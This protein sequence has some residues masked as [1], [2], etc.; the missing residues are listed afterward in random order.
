MV[1]IVAVALAAT[2]VPPACCQQQMVVAPGPEVVSLT[3]YNQNFGLVRETRTL[4]LQEGLNWV[5]VEDVAAQIDPTSVHL[6]G[7]ELPSALSVREQNYEYDLISPEAILRKAVGE[8]VIVRNYLQNGE[9]QMREGT[10]LN[11][12]VGNLVVEGPDG[13]VLRPTGEVSLRELPEGL[14]SRPALTWKLLSDRA[15]RQRAELSY[16]TQGISWVANYVAVINE[17]NTKLD[18]NGWV[19]LNNG[20]GASYSDADLQLIAGDVRRVEEAK[21]GMAMG[22]MERAEAEGAFEEKAFF[23]YH[24]YTMTEPTTIRDKETKQLG[25]LA[26]A[27]VPVEKQFVYDGAQSW[28]QYWSRYR[29][30][31]GGEPGA[32]RDTSDYHKVNVLLELQ[33]SEENHMGMA[34]PKGTVRCYMADDRGRLQ[35]LGEDEIDHTPRD[36]KIRLHIGDAFDVVGEHRRTDFVKL[37]P[38]RTEEAFEIKVRNHKEKED[39]LVHVVEHVV[40]DWRV[41]EKS[42]D[43]TEK[44]AHTLDF[45]VRV[46]PDGEVVVTYR[47]RIQW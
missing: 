44:D 4:D 7:L 3:V 20:S 45:P 9:V 22:G 46:P 14:I 41:L 2:I 35:F 29:G 8:H 37:G 13:V 16:M 26:A 36:E 30:Y 19:T 21:A 24:L 27:D 18:L 43:Y 28:W 15:G 32:G 23:E 6:K 33:N 40:G 39:V 25:L 42:H 38:G 10:L 12:E 11:G 31:G 47:V 17:A 34:L 5:R 1:S